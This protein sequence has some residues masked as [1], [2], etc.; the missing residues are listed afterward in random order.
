MKSNFLKVLYWLTLIFYISTVII[1]IKFPCIFPIFKNNNIEIYS[2]SLSFYYAIIG[3]L[4]GIII[5]TVQYINQKLDS[6]EIEKIPFTNFYFILTIVI[7]LCLIVFNNIFLYYKLINPFPTISLLSLITSILLILIN[8]YLTIAYLSINKVIN[9]YL[10]GILKKLKF[11][12]KDEIDYIQIRHKEELFI[13]FNIAMNAFD[14]HQAKI[15]YSSLDSIMK[16]LCNY[17]KYSKKKIFEDQLLDDFNDKVSILIDNVLKN[18]DEKYLENIADFIYLII[19]NII[20]NKAPTDGR[21]IFVNRWISTLE[22]LFYKSYPK[23]RT[24]VC[25]KC[26]EYINETSKYSIEKGLLI[27]SNEVYYNMNSIADKLVNSKEYWSA[28]LLQNLLVKYQN[29]IILLCK[30]YKQQ[31]IRDL[32]IILSFEKMTEI[33]NHTKENN[34]NYTNNSIIL[35]SIYGIDSQSYEFYKNDIY[36]FSNNTE[37]YY[38]SEIIKMQI[39][40]HFNIIIEKPE[41]N[42]YRVYNTFTELLFIIYN[43]KFNDNEIKTELIQK[44]YDTLIHFVSIHISFDVIKKNKKIN[45]DL[46]QHLIDFAA[47]MIYFDE[48][49]K[50]I[51]NYLLSIS[52][53]YEDLLG[54]QKE[55]RFLYQICKLIYCWL[56]LDKNDN[57]FD[58]IKEFLLKYY[59]VQ[60]SPYKSY[61]G[62]HDFPRLNHFSGSKIWYLPPNFIWGNEFQDK[63]NI[64]LNGDGYKYNKFNDYIFKEWNKKNV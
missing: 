29:H 16:I 21:N 63:I 50:N 61:I 53:F 45:R 37:E 26:L 39:D 20:E 40:F 56:E 18:R 12:K 31:K 51:L 28:I 25:H 44:L 38:V 11:S 24:T 1:Y 34:D 9:T 2:S 4:I 55:E 6:Q 60:D 41:K 14:K 17:L 19:K 33:I 10:R 35:A 36:K 54:E 7:I 22:S 47:V 23:Q 3:F 59:K 64:R 27:T 48:K 43:S 15:A 32:D 46:Q 42:D 49:N 58:S 8:I 30:Y 5:F 62:L 52:K 13:F 57:E